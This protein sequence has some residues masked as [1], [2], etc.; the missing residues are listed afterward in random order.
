MAWITL[1]GNICIFS[2]TSH[3]N[4]YIFYPF[5]KIQH[6]LIDWVMSNL[7]KKSDFHALQKFVIL[8]IYILLRKEKLCLSPFDVKFVDKF[9]KGFRDYLSFDWWKS[10]FFL[11]TDEIRKALLKV[12]QLFQLHMSHLKK[13]KKHICR[14]SSFDH[15]RF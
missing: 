3:T 9:R 10:A 2:T 1:S 14:L 13:N 11:D 7:W 12:Y 6:Q 8:K 5:T 4:D 15:L